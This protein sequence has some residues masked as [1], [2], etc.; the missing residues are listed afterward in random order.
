M[1]DDDSNDNDDGRAKNNNN[2]RR[3]V[4]QTNLNQQKAHQLLERIQ[5]LAGWLTGW[6]VGWLA[7]WMAEKC[8]LLAVE[9]KAGIL[10]CITNTSCKGTLMYVYM[11]GCHGCH[12][13]FIAFCP[14]FIL[15]IQ[16]HII[17]S[18]LHL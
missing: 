12:G 6:L 17:Q 11:H 7:G 14:Y 3:N 13:M 5:A 1:N 18:H 8:R 15:Y 4:F 16:S 2:G 9:T 10:L